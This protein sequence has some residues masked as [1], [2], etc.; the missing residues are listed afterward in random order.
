MKKL[1]L[2]MLCA[3]LLVSAVSC[4]SAPDEPAV[5]QGTVTTA[6]P[7][8]STEST[9]VTTE[10]PVTEPPIVVEIPEERLNEMS[11]T[12]QSLEDSVPDLYGWIYVDGTDIN[13][14]MVKGEDNDYYLNRATDRSWD[15]LGSIFVDYRN[16]WAVED[17]YNRNIVIY[18][19]NLT[20]GG[21]FHDV[22]KMFENEELFRSSYVY[23]YTFDGV[24][25]Y[26]PIAVY[27]AN[28]YYKYFRT[29]FDHGWEFTAFANGMAENSIYPEDVVFDEDDRMITL[30][31]CTNTYVDGRYVLQA[32]L[33]QVTRWE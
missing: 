19:H 13:Y 2:M 29:H 5:S 10:P 33:V 7:A 31:T 24:F 25:V 32:K 18:G 6:P 1:A 30:S 26:E 28:A 22:Q 23:I 9:T 27:E 3:A 20:W 21:M 16:R 8:E 4:Q 12:L 15:V 17:P 11:S 14:P